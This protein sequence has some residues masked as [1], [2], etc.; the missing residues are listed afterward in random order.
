MATTKK[1]PTTKKLS[2][3][4]SAKATVRPWS[5]RFSIITIG[6]YTIAVAT[7]VVIALSASQLITTHKNQARLD[8]IETVYSSINLDDSYRIE[9]SNVFGDKRVYEWDKGRT[10]SSSIEY[11]HADTVANTTADLDAKIKSAGFAF[12]EEPYPGSVYKQYHYKSVNGEY[13]RLTVSSKPYD[14]AVYNAFIMDKNLSG[15]N[16]DAIDKNVGPSKVT[17]KVNLDDNNE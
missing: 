6:I 9:N 12:T 14:D 3:T 7:A 10:Y 2:S 13:V 15:I 16:L 17:I 5:W 8:R 11:V 4:K 1:T